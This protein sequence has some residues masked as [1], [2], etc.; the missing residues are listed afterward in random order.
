MK[1]HLKIFTSIL[2]VLAC[3][4]F[5]PQMQAGTLPPETDGPPDGCFPNF[6]TAEGCMAL[7]GNQP[8]TGLGNTA[9][10]WR[11]LFFAGSAFWNTGTGAGALA[12]NTGDENTATGAGALLINVFADNNTAY[13]AFTLFQNQVGSDNTAVGQRALFNNRHW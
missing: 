9:L 5:L 13:G 6:A 8:F 12:I 1:N 2:S 10:G 3:C 4:A 11:S 7:N